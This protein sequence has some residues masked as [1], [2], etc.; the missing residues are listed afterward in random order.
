MMS[1]KMCFLWFFSLSTYFFKA[2]SDHVFFPSI[3]EVIL[4]SASSN[5]Y[6][7]RPLLFNSW[8]PSCFVN[9]RLFSTFPSSM[10]STFLLNL[11]PLFF[12]FSFHSCSWFILSL[13]YLHP[14]VLSFYLIFILFSL[15]SDFFP[16]IAKY[17]LTFHNWRGEQRRLMFKSFLVTSVS[18][19]VIKGEGGQFLIKPKNNGI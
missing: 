7:F 8:F 14:W 13:F 18:R 11:H 17:I 12:N 5:C 6:W 15:I 3:L 1:T 16:A 2:K 9:H 19:A 10:I 4:P